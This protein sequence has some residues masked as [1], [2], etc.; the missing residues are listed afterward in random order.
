MNSCLVCIDGFCVPHS[1]MTN[2]PYLCP[3]AWLRASS[4]PI[5][6][7][8][9]LTLILPR[10]EQVASCQKHALVMIQHVHILLVQTRNHIHHFWNRG[11]VIGVLPIHSRHILCGVSRVVI[12][13]HIGREVV[14]VAN[15]SDVV[16]E[17]FIKTNFALQDFCFV[18]IGSDSSGCNSNVIFGVNEK[19]IILNLFIK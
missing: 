11:E 12:H 6:H 18:Q 3:F 9:K 15:D 8:I 17:R 1:S 5:G 7:N 19:F 10:L 2:G 13:E 14:F 4:W 16:V